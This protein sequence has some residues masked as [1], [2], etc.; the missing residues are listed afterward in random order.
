MQGLTHITD[1]VYKD[2]EYVS[3]KLYSIE[4]GNTYSLKAN[5]KARMTWKPGATKASP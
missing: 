2:G 5:S 3:G 4:D 1:L